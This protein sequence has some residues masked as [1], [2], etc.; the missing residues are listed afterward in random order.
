MMDVCVTPTT[1]SS[2]LPSPS[3][4]SKATAFQSASLNDQEIII[5]DSWRP[6]V[7]ELEL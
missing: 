1:S 5:P 4:Q 6:E 7:F 3:L 2:S